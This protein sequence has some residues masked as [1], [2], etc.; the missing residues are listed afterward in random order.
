MILDIGN[1]EILIYIAYKFNIMID[2]I[3]ISKNIYDKSVKLC[4]KLYH[5]NF[6]NIYLGNYDVLYC[7]NLVF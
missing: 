7:C 2:G 6:K 5:Y 1:G 3:E 4:N